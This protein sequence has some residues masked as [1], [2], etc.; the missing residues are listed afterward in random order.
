MAKSSVAQSHCD[1]VVAACAEILCQSVHI[2]DPG[3][4]VYTSVTVDCP[5]DTHIIRASYGKASIP[6]QGGVAVAS[7]IGLERTHTHGCV[8]DTGGVV[9]ERLITDARVTV[10]FGIA[11]ECSIAY[12]RVR[13]AHEVARCEDVY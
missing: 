4:V 5:A 13:C 8:A 1:V 3:S 12:G 7:R 6:A 9:L 10:A 11:K 2:A